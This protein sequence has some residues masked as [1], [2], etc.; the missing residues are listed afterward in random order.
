VG[1][2]RRTVEGLRNRR[3]SAVALFS[4]AGALARRGVHQRST[5]D[6]VEAY[7]LFIEIATEGTEDRFAR[8][9]PIALMNATVCMSALPDEIAAP[10]VGELLLAGMKA[11]EYSEVGLARNHIIRLMQRIENSNVVP[12]VALRWTRDNTDRLIPVIRSQRNNLRFVP[13]SG[14]SGSWSGV[15]MLLRTNARL[16]TPE[17]CHVQDPVHIAASCTALVVRPA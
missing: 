5:A 16:L 15:S 4:L 13:S 3:R 9:R 1:E 12:L 8:Y 11:I 7:A 17:R 10:I 2:A 14:Y 6:L